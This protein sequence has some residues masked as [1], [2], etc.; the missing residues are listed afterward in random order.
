M[1]VIDDPS[2]S[3]EVSRYVNSIANGEW[4]SMLEAYASCFT[5]GAQCYVWI[6]DL[7]REP[8]MYL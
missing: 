5:Y 3:K 4:G 6:N 1:A 8:M 7:S 2:D